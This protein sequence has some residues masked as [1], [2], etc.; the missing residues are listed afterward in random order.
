MEREPVL[1]FIDPRDPKAATQI[2]SGLYSDGWMSDRATVLLKRPE[3]PEPLTVTIYISDQAPARHIE[4]SSGSQMIAEK[5]FTAPGVYTISAPFAPA[6]S[7]VTVTLSVDKTFS[8]SAD[9]RKLGVVVTGIG[10]R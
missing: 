7:S 10:F 5:T 4:I 6:S 9:R 3:K 8:T 2:V 1:T